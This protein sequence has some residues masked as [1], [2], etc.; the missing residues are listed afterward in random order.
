M[1][2][3]TRSLLAV[4]GAA[5]LVAV[6]A[7]G[8]SAETEVDRPDSFTSA[9]TVMATPDN[10]VDM[11]G[12]P[13]GGE[14][15][16]TGTFNFEINSD[17][18]IICY[19]ITLE[20]VAESYES[21]ARTATHIHEANA[22]E[23]GPPRVVFPNPSGDGDVLTSSGCLQGPFTTGVEGPDGNDTGEGFTLAEIE[24][25][26]A[27]YYGDV[28][29]SQ[30]VPGSVRGQL[31]QVPVGSVPTGFGGAAEQ[32]GGLSTPVL[33]SGAALAAL[34]ATALTVGAVRRRSEG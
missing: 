31:Q 17:L 14:P 8:A 33:L 26:P 32:E 9:F 29:G 23:S 34:G 6:T 7:P 1:R 28:H 19:D 2:T 4:A 12:N 3:Q 10:V 24:A 27:E 16:A 25:D 18:E 15:G 13:T 5:T 21:P 20:G 22:G 11:E 30:S